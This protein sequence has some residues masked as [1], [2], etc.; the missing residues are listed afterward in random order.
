MR[1]TE[2]HTECKHI[3][4]SG[5]EIKSYCSLFKNQFSGLFFSHEWGTKRESSN[6]TVTL[7]KPTVARRS[8]SQKLETRA[9]ISADFLVG[10]R[11]FCQSTQ[12]KSFVD[13]SANFQGFCHRWSVG[14]L[15]PDDRPTFWKIFHNDIGRRSPDHRAWIGRRSPDGRS[16]PF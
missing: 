9:P 10:R 13:R 12:V 4:L 7:P 11:L 5:F 15:L 16:M 3:L 14:R 2:W 1:Q 6:S 8:V